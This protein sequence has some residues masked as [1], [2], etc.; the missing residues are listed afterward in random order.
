MT[1][2]LADEILAIAAVVGTICSLVTAGVALGLI[3]KFHANVSRMAKMHGLEPK[4]LE[5]QAHQTAAHPAVYSP[6]EGPKENP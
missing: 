3:R 5:E 1:S 4:S 2:R 6:G